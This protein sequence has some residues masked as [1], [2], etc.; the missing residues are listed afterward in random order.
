[1]IWSK[2]KQLRWA[3]DM[4]MDA[5]QRLLHSNVRLRADLLEAQK[6]LIKVGKG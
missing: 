5:Y 2:I 3:R 4:W 1:M 6:D